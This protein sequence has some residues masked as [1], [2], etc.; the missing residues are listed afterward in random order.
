MDFP[1]LLAQIAVVLIVARLVGRLFRS[2]GQPQ[3]I[4]EMVGGI[5]LG[6]SFLGW[7]APRSSAA[8]FP[9]ASLGLLD[10]VSKIGL[11]LFIFLVGTK[12]DVR[13][14]RDRGR[15]LVL[16]SNAGIAA[17]FVLGLLLAL[18]LHRRLSLPGV[19][20]LHFALFMATAMSITAVPVL[21]RILMERGLLKSPAGT[22]VMACAAADDAQAWCILAVVVFLVRA[23]GQTAPLWLT[24]LGSA[25]YVCAMLLGVRRALR[26]LEAMWRER[27]ALTQSMLAIVLLSL[28]VSAW[29]TERL[30]IHALFGAFLLG[31]VMPRDPGFVQA[32]SAK[33]EDL[34]VVLLLPLFFASAGLRTSIGLLGD[35]RLWLDLLLIIATAIAGKLGGAALAARLGGMSWREAATIGI[36]MNTRGL[37]E[38]VVLNIGLEIGVISHSVFTMMVLM[39]LVTTLM[40]APL[41]RLMQPKESPV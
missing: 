4:G 13:T 40:T 2:I 21:A 27:G 23:G 18:A 22:V 26:R 10:T 24:I 14:L 5:L 7:L 1:L 16:I 35:G 31:A 20:L 34:T 17:P 41:L 8:L 36:L 6:P 32:L 29:L 11:V 19:G 38:L 3:V 39:A 33:M 12:L 9:Q 28:L 15:A 30:G 25:V 37:M